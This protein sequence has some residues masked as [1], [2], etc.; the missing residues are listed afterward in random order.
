MHRTVVIE[1]DKQ[2]GLWRFPEFGEQDSRQ[3]GRSVNL[4]ERLFQGGTKRIIRHSPERE[5]RRRASK[6]FGTRQLDRHHPQSF[7]VAR[8]PDGTHRNPVVD[9]KDLSSV[10][11]ECQE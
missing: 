1:A 10:A 9:L 7:N 2:I 4:L 8:M 3:I 5:V 11:S 6:S